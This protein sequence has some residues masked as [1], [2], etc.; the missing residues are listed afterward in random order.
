MFDNVKYYYSLYYEVLE[1]T[2]YSVINEKNICIY[3]ET[4]ENYY[5]TK[6]IFCNK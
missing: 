1:N 6:K 3:R 4:C 2:N 5:S